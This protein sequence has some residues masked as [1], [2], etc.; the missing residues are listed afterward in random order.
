[1]DVKFIDSRKFF[2]MATFFFFFIFFF[3]IR[4]FVN[5]ACFLKIA[6]QKI[7][8]KRKLQ[9][10]HKQSTFEERETEVGDGTKRR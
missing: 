1:M 10:K 4:S 5:D 9:R 7:Y 6:R 2:N 8:A 3:L